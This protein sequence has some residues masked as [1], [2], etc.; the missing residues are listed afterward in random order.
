MEQY[1]NSY[2]DNSISPIYIPLLPFGV[3]NDCLVFL[4]RYL[5]FI[6]EAFIAIFVIQ[7]TKK[8]KRMA[9]LYGL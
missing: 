1:F 6:I 5:D 4:C 8:N 9:P 2:Y 7:Q 3:N